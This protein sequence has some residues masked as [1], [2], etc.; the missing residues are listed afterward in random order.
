MFAIGTPVAR[1]QKA[2]NCFAQA[3]TEGA[4][5]RI[6]TGVAPIG[7]A[8]E[9]QKIIPSR[10]ENLYQDFSQFITKLTAFWIAERGPGPERLKILL[11]PMR[12]MSFH[13]FPVNLKRLPHQGVLNPLGEAFIQPGWDRQMKQTVMD[14]LVNQD[15]PGTVDG[16]EWKGDVRVTGIQEHS[17]ALR[18]FA[19]GIEMCDV[20][21]VI[22][23]IAQD[24]QGALT[25][26]LA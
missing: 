6:L 7:G 22:I 5:G 18:M 26:N 21:I 25:V 3:L 2:T 20:R 9:S 16:M 14:K 15:L 11:I 4:L 17:R 12:R 23:Q 8:Y 1:P 13:H 10:G 24:Q 19:L